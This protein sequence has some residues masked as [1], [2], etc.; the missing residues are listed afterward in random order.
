MAA[1]HVIIFWY[2][3]SRLDEDTILWSH[4]GIGAVLSV[5]AS[6]M[7]AGYSGKGWDDRHAKEESYRD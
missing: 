3:A 7:K 2:L 6:R 4:A 5:E 1:F